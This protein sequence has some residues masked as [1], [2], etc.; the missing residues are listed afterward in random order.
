[1]VPVT[2]ARELNGE[3]GSLQLLPAGARNESQRAAG[4]LG[5]GAWCPLTDQWSAMYVFDVLIY[6][7]GRGQRD[8]I[9][10]PES[11]QLMLIGHQS[12]FGKQQHR[13]PWSDAIELQL[14]DA[15]IKALRSLDDTT[16]ESELGDVLDKRRL[17]ALA[18]RRD[19][20]LQDAAK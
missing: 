14:G 18:S 6:S 5:G 1:M 2:I 17:A 10:S 15:W 11:W 9:Y 8:I 12:S 16:L 20:L 13:P 19:E 3:S 4:R 7:P